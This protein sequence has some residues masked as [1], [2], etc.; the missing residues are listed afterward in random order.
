MKDLLTI[1]S[2]LGSV[3]LSEGG[4]KMESEKVAFALDWD[5][6]A[7]WVQD[8]LMFIVEKDDPTQ[9]TLTVLDQTGRRLEFVRDE[10]QQSHV[11]MR[12]RTVYK[13]RFMPVQAYCPRDAILIELDG[14]IVDIAAGDALIRDQSGKISRMARHDFIARYQFVAPAG[15]A[16]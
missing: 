1:F 8:R 3:V 10:L 4:L 7:L 9:E 12:D 2:D 11:P 16:P 5:A 14:A 13:P 6:Q 15:S